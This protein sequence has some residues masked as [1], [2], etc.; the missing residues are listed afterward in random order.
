MNLNEIFQIAW[1]YLRSMWRFRWYSLVLTWLVVVIGWV[2]VGTMPDQYKVDAK[3]YVDTESVLRPLM[4][5]LTLESNIGNRLRLLSKTLLSRPN[6]EKLSRL[7]DLDVTATNPQQM[8]RLLNNLSDNI[9]LRTD[10]RDTNLYN[11]SYSNRN[12]EVANKVVKGLLTILVESTLGESR[13]NSSTAQ[14]FLDRQIAEYGD[15]LASA[16]Q[17]LNDFK[18]KNAKLM[19][20]LRKGYFQSL[21][22][23]QVELEKSELNL[24][25]ATNKRD[26]IQRQMR[27][28]EPVLGLGTPQKSKYVSSPLDTKIVE[29]K[30]QRNELLLKYTELHPQVVSIDEKIKLLESQKRGEVTEK[31]TGVAT[32]PDLDKNPVYQQLKISL[33]QTETQ[34]A[35]LS[36]RV[37]EF[38]DRTKSLQSMVDTIPNVETELSKL[39]REY[40]VN[41]KNYNA[42]VSRLE[43]AK[44]SEEVEQTGEGVKIRVIDPPSFPNSPSGPNRKILNTAV[45]AIGLVVGLALS[46]VFSQIKP[47]F[48]EHRELR[49]ELGLPVLGSV[50]RIKTSELLEKKKIEYGVFVGSTSVLFLS[51]GLVLII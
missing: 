13:E 26:E 40:E 8:E 27:G 20:T 30:D 15:R 33:A 10:R 50:S 5:G 2:Y 35:T 3:L 42:L 24:K 11:I 38:K 1:T 51:Y 47:V 34:I 39:T 16:E 49:N 48:H 17:K 32:E 28:E 18:R 19:P 29:L 43:T 44:M 41:K 14:E 31:E 45:L 22:T 23:S 7:S 9:I 6:M 4:R 37:K 12:P 36:V 25:E 46:F 21:Q